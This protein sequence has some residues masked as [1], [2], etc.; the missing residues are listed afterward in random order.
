M[1]TPTNFSVT[2]LYKKV[3]NPLGAEVTRKPMLLRTLAALVFRSN[4]KTVEESITDLESN[5]ANVSDLGT[6]AAKNVPASGNAS[7][8]QVVMGNDTRLS[9]A[10]TPVSHTH[11]KSQITDFPTLGTASAKDVPTSGNASNTQVVMGNDTRLSD[12][13][14]PV[15]HTHTK[16]QITDFPSSMPASDVSSWAK[17]ASKPSYNYSEIGGVLTVPVNPATPPTE[18]GA[19]WLTTT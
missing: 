16:S 2:N 1:A 8:S 12:A 3:L 4:G 18:N 6:A 14:T 11:T 10:R 5:K 9:D 13:R 19:I 17:A 15:S 7:T